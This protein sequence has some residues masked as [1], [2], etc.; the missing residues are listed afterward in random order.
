MCSASCGNRDPIQQENEPV[1]DLMDKLS[2]ADSSQPNEHFK[3]DQL[4]I[5]KGI[6]R[7]ALIIVAPVRIHTPLHDITGKATIRGLVAPVFNTG[8]GVQLDLFLSRSGA[9]DHV[10]SRLYDPGRNAGDRDWIPLIIPL[11]IG[12]EDC[13]ELEISAGPQG[14]LTADWLAL[15]FLGL[16]QG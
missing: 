7:K 3:P 8:D 11:E 15:G 9:R 13:L 1:L 5:R 4:V 6:K 2:L 10:G 12:E 16:F 14:D